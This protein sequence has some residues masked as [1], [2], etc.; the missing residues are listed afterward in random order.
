MYVVWS[1]LSL[2]IPIWVLCDNDALLYSLYVGSVLYLRNCQTSSSKMVMQMMKVM[3]FIDYFHYFSRR[4][5]DVLCV[6]IYNNSAFFFL[7][8]TIVQIT[9]ANVGECNLRKIGDHPP[10]PRLYISRCSCGPQPTIAIQVFI[11]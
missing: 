10:T 3:Y 6:F 7:D 8:W 11:S 2:I 4:C 1:V 5:F 9:S